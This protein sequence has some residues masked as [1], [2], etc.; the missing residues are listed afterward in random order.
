MLRY[1]LAKLVLAAEDIRA[2]IAIFEREAPEDDTTAHAVV[3][4]RNAC[5]E[6]LDSFSEVHERLVRMLNFVSG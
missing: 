6:V 5:G 3:E 2:A 1:R 4:L